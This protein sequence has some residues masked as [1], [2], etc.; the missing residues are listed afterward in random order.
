MNDY[1]IVLDV[2]AKD[3]S[4][5]QTIVF[6]ILCFVRELPKPCSI[7]EILDHEILDLGPVED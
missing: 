6:G 2:R 1:Q 5:V 4:Q 7:N 3:R